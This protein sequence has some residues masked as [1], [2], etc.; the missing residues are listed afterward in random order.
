MVGEERGKGGGSCS[1]TIHDLFEAFETVPDCGGT[2][3]VDVGGLGVGFL[4]GGC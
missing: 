1:R 4:G 2:D 3:D